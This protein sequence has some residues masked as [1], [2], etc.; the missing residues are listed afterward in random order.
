MTALMKASVSGHIITVTFL[1]TKGANIELSDEV[2]YAVRLQYLSRLRKQVI[3]YCIVRVK[4]DVT[5]SGFQ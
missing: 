3:E 1:L 4:Y 2:R 5:D